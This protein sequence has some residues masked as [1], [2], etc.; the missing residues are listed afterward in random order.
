MLTYSLDKNKEEILLNDDGHQIMMEW[1]RPYME[2]CIDMLQPRGHVLEI[3]FGL[4]Y[5]ATQIQK[6]KPLSHTIVECDP[7]VIKKAK[8]WAKDYNNII[9][10]EDIW[11]KVVCTDRLKIY[12]EVFMDDFPLEYDK[13]NLRESMRQANRLQLFV[14]LMLNYHL[15]S[16]SKISAY[17]CPGESLHEDEYWKGK[18]IDNPVWKYT[19]KI[20]DVVISDIQKY[21]YS[22][23]SAIIPLLTV[24]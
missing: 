6:Y 17:I 7:I 21:H 3:G 20:I 2:A 24:S 23:K 19:E 18:Y 15:R 9:I 22:A 5:S 4:G 13:T 11:Q 8:E 10:V 12:D 16:G 1:E 14:D